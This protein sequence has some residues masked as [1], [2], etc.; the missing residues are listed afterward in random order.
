MIALLA[1]ILAVAKPALDLVYFNQVM[2]NL[3]D[4]EDVLKKLNEAYALWPDLDDELI[5]ALKKEKIRLED[6][7]TKQATIIQAKAP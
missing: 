1:A 3:N 7:L 6:A 2:S 4:Y 5:G